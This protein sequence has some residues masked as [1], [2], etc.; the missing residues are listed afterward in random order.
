MVVVIAASGAVPA[1]A[2]ARASDSGRIGS[3]PESWVRE[4]SLAV[5]DNA[6]GI[7]LGEAATLE[8][9]TM[10]F[11]LVDPRGNTVSTHAGTRFT[12]GPV[13]IDT[14]GAP[15][16]Y[17]LRVTADGAAAGTWQF[18]M[19]AIPPRSW[20]ALSLA[21]G[22]TMVL[23]AA[24]SVLFWRRASGAPWRWFWAGAGLWAVGVAMKVAFAV[25]FN[26][27][28]LA[29]LERHLG[30]G[31]YLACGSVYIGLLTGVFEVGIVALAALVWRRMAAE[32]RGAVAVGVGAGAVEA[33]LLGLGVIAAG[34]VALAGRGGN[35]V[36]A[37]SL[38]TAATP[39]AWLTG[40]VER[41]I[42]ILC[43]VAARTLALYGVARRSWWPFWAG[44]AL[45]TAVD[46]VAGSAHVSGKLGTFSDWWIEA[47][48]LPFA[49]A[50]VALTKWAVRR[51]PGN[52]GGLAPTGAGPSP[53]LATP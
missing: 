6:Q 2:A 11:E 10:R 27:P 48:I 7:A 18:A 22:V 15:G 42:A 5:S 46:T 39:L 26:R 45:L 28:I 43:H 13:G 50:S 40:P 34:A 1:L 53:T 17:R 35:A 16:L 38:M 14:A 8:R 36:A 52:A 30:R 31:A 24:A 49:L 44:F 41:V 19:A 25:A 4:Y 12:M 21:G 33:A 47:A 3:A 32:A 37:M 29:W 51:W 23:I 20:A 9:G